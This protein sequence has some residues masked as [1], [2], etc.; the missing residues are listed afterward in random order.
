MKQSNVESFFF[1]FPFSELQFLTPSSE[2][3]NTTNGN[4]ENKWAPRSWKNEESYSSKLKY[5]V[6]IP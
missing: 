1:F 2:V 4:K 6:A 5:K 3:A